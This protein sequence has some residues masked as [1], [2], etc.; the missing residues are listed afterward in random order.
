[1]YYVVEWDNLLPL[2][3]SALVFL[4]E[5]ISE[6][7]STLGRPIVMLPVILFT[8]DTSGNRHM[9]LTLGAYE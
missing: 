1:M 9:S 4:F 6:I 3:G 7:Y 8:D 2:V 5:G